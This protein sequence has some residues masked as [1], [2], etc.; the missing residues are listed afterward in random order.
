MSRRYGAA[1]LPTGTFM[2]PSQ[3]ESAEYYDREQ[4]AYIVKQIRESDGSLLPPGPLKLRVLTSF[5]LLGEHWA[6]G[7]T[8][9]IEHDQT[10]RPL[11]QFEVIGI[12]DYKLGVRTGLV[13]DRKLPH[14]VFK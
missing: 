3:P 14:W 9:F 10:Q 13:P 11:G 1:L 7:T 8:H 5:G 4:V 12:R 6:R 2:N